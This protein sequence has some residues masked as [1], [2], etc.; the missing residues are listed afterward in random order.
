[1][2][3]LVPDGVI[4]SSNP[5]SLPANRHR[6]KKM[7]IEFRTPDTPLLTRDE[8]I[9]LLKENPKYFEAGDTP[10]VEILLDDVVV[11]RTKKLGKVQ[12][13]FNA[14]LEDLK[15]IKE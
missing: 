4:R 10:I 3:E 12:R 5:E 11:H 8:V 9:M 1:M 14:L 13:L 6:N 2:N 7:K 15:K